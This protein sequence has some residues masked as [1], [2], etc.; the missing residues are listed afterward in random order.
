MPRGGVFSEVSGGVYCGAVNTDALDVA[1]TAVAA[2]AVAVANTRRCLER[3]KHQWPMVKEA[4]RA[5]CN[6]ATDFFS[7]DSGNSGRLATFV[8]QN[9]SAQGRAACGY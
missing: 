1:M 4:G 3:S 2:K 8:G 9:S 5:L 7:S 6:A